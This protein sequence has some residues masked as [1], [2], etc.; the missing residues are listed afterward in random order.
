MKLMKL[1]KSNIAADALWYADNTDETDHDD[2]ADEVDEDEQGY[3]AV[4]NLLVKLVIK[5]FGEAVCK[6]VWWGCL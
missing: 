4:V 3:E 5:L 1:I 2:E 6:A